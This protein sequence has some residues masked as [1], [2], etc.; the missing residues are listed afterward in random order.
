MSKKTIFISHLDLNG[1][2]LINATIEASAA[3][4]IDALPGRLYF[5]TTTTHLKYYDGFEWKSIGTLEEGG[6]L[7]PADVE[8]IVEDLTSDHVSAQVDNENLSLLTDAEKT[9]NVI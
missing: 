6:G 8:A 1:H 9:I 3:D 7:T 2:E 4:P 5:N